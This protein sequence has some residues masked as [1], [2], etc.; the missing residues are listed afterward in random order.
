MKK[1]WLHIVQTYLQVAFLFYYKKIIACYQAPI[2]LDKPVLFLSNHQNA[3]LDPLLITIKSKRKNYFLT[4]ASVFKNK[5]VAKILKSLQMLPVYRVRDG[6]SN[7]SKNHQIFSICAEVLHND[8][9]IILFP[10]GS[11]SLNRSVRNL[12]KGFT[13]IIDETLSK[14][15]NTDIQIIPVGLNFQH[16]KDWADSVS[17]YFGKPIFISNY[18]SENKTVKVKK[19]KEKVKQEI[20]KLTTHI[21]PGEQYTTTEKKLTKMQVDYTKPEAVNQCLTNGFKYKHKTVLP[22]SPLFKVF[23]VG[24]KIIFWLPYLVWRGAVLPK[25]K[26]DEFIGTFRFAVI[27]TLAPIFLIIQ[28]VAIGYLFSSST[29]I[30]FFTFALFLAWLTPK[31]R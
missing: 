2:S 31:L 24:V 15:P 20:A 3:L 4:R 29:G 10:E 9:S 17:V 28:S 18:L 11:H 27:L 13:R 8:K 30:L 16:P 21:E 22:A 23:S 14:Y 1:L 26:E 25:I 12:S 6:F 7:L 5:F 19:L